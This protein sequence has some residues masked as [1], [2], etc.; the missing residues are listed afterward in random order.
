MH[1]AIPL[2]PCRFL[3]GISSFPPIISNPLADSNPILKYAGYCHIS[4]CTGL[5]M[6]KS[7]PAVPLFPF[8]P[9]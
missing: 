7:G 2:Y 3:A 8:L 5:Y 4:R 6:Q 1:A 9:D